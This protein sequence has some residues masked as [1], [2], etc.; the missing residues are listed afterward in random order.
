MYFFEVF[1]ISLPDYFLEIFFILAVIVFAFSRLTK[2][3]QSF[4]LQFNKSLLRVPQ[5]KR[6]LA[7]VT[8]ADVQSYKELS[9]YH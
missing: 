1:K 3:G 8:S 7:K 9:L 6:M 2:R 5:G 4:K